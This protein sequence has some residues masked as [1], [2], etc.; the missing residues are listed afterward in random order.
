MNKAMD[1]PDG[2]GFRLPRGAA[3]LPLVVDLD[4]GLLR[5]NPALCLLKTARNTNFLAATREGFWQRGRP[6]R[7]AM[8]AARRWPGLPV[9]LQLNPDVADLVRA[10]GRFGAQVVVVSSADR[11]MTERVVAHLGFR[12]RVYGS[13]PE[14]F[15]DSHRKSRLLTALFGPHRFIYVGGQSSQE[16]ICLNSRRTIMVD[17]PERM[18]GRLLTS[19]VPLTL[20]PSPVW[21][22]V[23]VAAGKLLGTQDADMSKEGLNRTASRE[24]WANVDQAR[25][26]VSDSP[27]VD[28]P[29]WKRHGKR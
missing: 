7:L 23:V 17:L 28:V 20:L 26:T 22:N 18:K 21:R 14:H 27:A 4:G 19:G 24:I 29:G 12:M 13:D 10:Y 9:P 15:L 1:C 8:Q 11:A 2:T 16:V 5:V 25:P 3:P 6:D